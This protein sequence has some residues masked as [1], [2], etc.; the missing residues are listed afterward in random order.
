MGKNGL[1][2]MTLAHCRAI[3]PPT[4]P[5][6]RP[7][8]VRSLCGRAVCFYWDRSTKRLRNVMYGLDSAY[9][10]T[11]VPK[12]GLNISDKS[13][14][15]QKYRNSKNQIYFT[16]VYIIYKKNSSH[17]ISA[18][19][20]TLSSVGRYWKFRQ[21]YLSWTEETIAIAGRPNISTPVVI[22]EQT[23]CHI[24]NTTH[25]EY[26]E[27]FY[28]YAKF[29]WN[30]AKVVP[31]YKSLIGSQV[32]CRVFWTGSHAVSTRPGS[33]SPGVATS[34]LSVRMLLIQF[35]CWVWEW[36]P[37]MDFSRGNIKFVRDQTV[38]SDLT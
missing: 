9:S 34:G 20:T 38:L 18:L 5:Y 21:L 28:H 23:A 33:R 36:S 22:G 25:E 6:E 37:I 24:F 1:L 29:G 14:I 7:N 8:Y 15:L 2:V 16:I 3:N 35:V 32:T 27:V 12:P 30:I 13:N 11:C 19:C 10:S 4:A 31:Y 26:L 17:F